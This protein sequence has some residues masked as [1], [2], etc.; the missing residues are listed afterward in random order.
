MSP[1]ARIEAAGDEG[2][3][4]VAAG[5]DAV[6]AAGAVCLA[7]SGNVEDGAVHREVDGEFGVLAAIAG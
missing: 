2:P 6:G 3:G 4:S 7:A 5:K 1:S